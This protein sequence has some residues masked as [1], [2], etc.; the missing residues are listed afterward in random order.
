MEELF[1]PGL[2]I[3]PMT[4]EIPVTTVAFLGTCVRSWAGL[5]QMGIAPL[6]RCGVVLNLGLLIQCLGKCFLMV[7]PSWSWASLGCG[8]CHL[9]RPVL[10]SLM[11]EQKLS[12]SS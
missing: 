3:S 8:L 5:A 1:Q 10:Q 6:R 11:P 4:E 2:V 12:I 7:S 9:S